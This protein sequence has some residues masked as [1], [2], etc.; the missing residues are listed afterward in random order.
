ML[1]LGRCSLPTLLLAARHA[2]LRMALPSVPLAMFWNRSRTV[3]EPMRCSPAVARSFGGLGGRSPTPLQNAVWQ[4]HIYSLASLFT[5]CDVMPPSALP[6]R[7]QSSIITMSCAVT[8]SRCRSRT[9][10]SLA[11]CVRSA[12]F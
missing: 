7:R 10:P 12:T 8:P 1:V 6:L 4:L 9:P 5:S 3:L 11:L 2:P